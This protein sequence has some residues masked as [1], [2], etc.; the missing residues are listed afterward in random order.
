VD[1]AITRRG[2]VDGANLDTREAKGLAALKMF[3]MGGLLVHQEFIIQVK[4][5]VNI[6]TAQLTH[7]NPSA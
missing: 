6:V 4:E 5:A 1:S 2:S 7:S 3:I